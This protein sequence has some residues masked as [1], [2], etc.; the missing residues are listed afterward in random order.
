MHFYEQALYIWI[1]I[2]DESGQAETRANLVMALH[3]LGRQSEA[4]GQANA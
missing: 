4:I 3:G 1:R 2:G